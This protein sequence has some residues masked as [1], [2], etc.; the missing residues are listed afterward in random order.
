[1]R[2]R[3]LTHTAKLLTACSQR[4]TACGEA[5]NGSR[6]SRLQDAAKPPN[7]MLQT[8][9][10]EA[11]GGRAPTAGVRQFSSTS[12]VTE[13]LLL[14]VQGRVDAQ[15]ARRDSGPEGRGLERA[16]AP[17]QAVEGTPAQHPASRGS[18]DAPDP[19]GPQALAGPTA[20]LDSA[21]RSGLLRCASARPPLTASGLDSGDGRSAERPDAGFLEG[22]T[23]ARAHDHNAHT[24][25]FGSSVFPCFWRGQGLAMTPA[26]RRDRGSRGGMRAGAAGLRASGSRCDL[27]R[28]AAL[29]LCRPRSVGRGG[30]APSAPRSTRDVGQRP[31][32]I[33]ESDRHA[34][35]GAPLWREE[36]RSVRRTKLTGRASA[37]PAYRSRRRAG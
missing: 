29:P 3:S 30:S 8:A 7:H 5:V 33:C 1:M 12:A 35:R 14:R 22:A 15:T 19:G 10:R 13:R 2:C 21:G 18:S 34:K 26:R 9:T 27:R 4:R 31:P 11:V 16:R 37:H 25:D 23:A 20:L 28:R 32:P 6:P 36:E 17:T 24:L